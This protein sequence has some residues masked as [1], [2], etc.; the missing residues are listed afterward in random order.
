MSWVWK[1]DQPLRSEE[2]VARE[3]HEVALARGLDDL[4]SVLAL[5]CIRQES[6]FWCPWNRADPSSEK[7][8]HDSE[9]DDGRSVGYFQQ[10]NGV[11]GENPVGRDNWWGDMSTRMDLKRSCNTFLERLSDD[12]VTVGNA[13]QA[14]GFIQ[15]VQGSA[16]PNAYAKHWDYCWDLLKRA[17]QQG[18]IL[19]VPPET[20]VPIPVSVLRPDFEERQ[21]YGWAASKRSRPPI[22]F[23]IHTQEGSWDATAEDLAQF[24]Q[25][26]N[27]VSYHYTVRDGIVYDVV[28]TDL[29]AWA[30]LNAN[31]FSIN[32]CFAGSSVSQTRQQW[33][34]RY[35]RDI[36]IAAYLAVQDARKYGF[37]TEVIAPPYEGRARPGVSDHKYVTEKLGIGTHTDVGGNFPWDLF[38]A[39]VNQFATGMDEIMPSLTDG[40]SLSI[41]RTNDEKIGLST[42]VER[43]TNGMLHE[44]RVEELALLGVPYELSLVKRI[45]EGDKSMPA[46]AAGQPGIADRA[47]AI[48]AKASK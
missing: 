30:V 43:Q 11:P 13:A 25:G 3:V 27:E 6:G 19:P 26:Q 14:T 21:M 4:A 8:P 16:Y 39:H 35:E 36:E 44:A 7:Y 18:P 32:L 40:P 47:K 37:S 24:C 33:L 10:Q 22:N 5:M 29:Y 17:M 46:V 23:F 20:P 38:T 41:Y 2:Q 42:P 1:A 31:V 15:R 9:S 34:D 12:Y 45:A 48:L 28:D